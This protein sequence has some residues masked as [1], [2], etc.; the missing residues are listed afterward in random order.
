MQR[1]A[2]LKVLTLGAALAGL[3]LIG[4]GAAAAQTD[5]PRVSAVTSCGPQSSSATSPDCQN[6]GPSTTRCQTNG[7]CQIVTTPPKTE[8]GLYGP[9]F[10]QNPNVGGVSPAVGSAIR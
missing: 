10:W 2:T 4:A 8:A 5:V 1:P 7:S 6:T 9:F 3:S